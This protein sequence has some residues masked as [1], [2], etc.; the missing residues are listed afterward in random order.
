MAGTGDL[1]HTDTI[2]SNVGSA[3]LSTVTTANSESLD[4]GVVPNN[5]EV[6]TPMISKRKMTVNYH[7]HS[8]LA[9]ALR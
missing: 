4:L 6:H 1:A 8:K 9:D 2:T 5:Q 7:R 3:A